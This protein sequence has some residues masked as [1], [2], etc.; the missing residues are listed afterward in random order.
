M[1]SS[2][3]KHKNRLARWQFSIPYGQ[4]TKY[5]AKRPWPLISLTMRYHLFTLC[6]SFTC[7]PVNADIVPSMYSGAPNNAKVT[8]TRSSEPLSESQAFAM[9]LDFLAADRGRISYSDVPQWE[10]LCGVAESMATGGGGGT[11]DDADARLA[12]IRELRDMSQ[13][14]PI[15]AAAECI[16]E[17]AACAGKGE[18]VADDED[19]AADAHA[20]NSQRISAAGEEEGSEEDSKAAKEARKNER[21]ERKAE[22]KAKKEAKR[23]RKEAKKK[24]RKRDESQ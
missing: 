4:R 14:G 19:A 5:D 6:C 17:D 11:D 9:L 12:K 21:R 24:K 18:H 1:R 2:R 13:A 22:K 20:E 16:P 7:F 10:D 8:A 15:T 3:V 23:E